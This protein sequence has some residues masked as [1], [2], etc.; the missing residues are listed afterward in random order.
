MASSPLSGVGQSTGTIIRLWYDG[1]L[2]ELDPQSPNF[3]D[4]ASDRESSDSYVALRHSVALTHES[5]PKWVSFN[6]NP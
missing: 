4:E 1:N 3:A 6:G 2:S 5:S